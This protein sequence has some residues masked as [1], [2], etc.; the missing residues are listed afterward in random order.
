[1]EEHLGVG[2]RRLNVLHGHALV[3]R[4]R[5]GVALHE[6]RDRL[7]EPAGPGGLFV[8]EGVRHGIHYTGAYVDYRIA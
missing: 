8:F 1:M 7:G 3:K 6:L 2:Q 5:G 4:H